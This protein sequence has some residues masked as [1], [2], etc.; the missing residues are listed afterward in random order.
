MFLQ[1]DQITS[2]NKSLKSLLFCLH[3]DEQ[4]PESPRLQ[5]LMKLK[6][7]IEGGGRQQTPSSPE[8]TLDLADIPLISQSG[9]K[10]AE[11][12][13]FTIPCLN[14]CQMDDLPALEPMRIHVRSQG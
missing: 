14:T 1:L 3:I 5:K 8:R 7:E 11:L 10:A 4:A 6:E 13:H 9:K 2:Q 12:D